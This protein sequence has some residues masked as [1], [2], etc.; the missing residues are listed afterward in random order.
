[1]AVTTAPYSQ[2]RPRITPDGT[3]G[4]IIVWQD[5]RSGA[6]YDVYA[7]RLDGNGVPQWTNDGVAISRA[8]NNPQFLFPQ[9][10][11]DGS[12]GAV[13]VWQD[14][15]N[16]SW[17]MYAQRIDS[18]GIVQWTP[19]GAA[20]ST[21]GAS[22]HYVAC[23]VPDG[24]GG[25]IIAW[26]S[27]SGANGIDVYAQKLNGSG[28]LQWG[29]PGVVLSAAPAD[30][31]YLQMAP[32]GSGGAI[33]VWED[34]RVGS[35]FRDI[36]AQRVDSSGN[37]IWTADGVPV[38]TADYSQYEPQIVNDGMGG[39]IIAW[40][41]YRN[42]NNLNNGIIQGVDIFVQRINASGN[43]VWTENGKAVS[44]ADL[45]QMYPKIV[46]DRSGGA[47]V[48]WEDERSGTSVDIYAQ[49]I[50]TSGHQ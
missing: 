25:A 39:A 41:D 8:A 15:R 26:E 16:G 44:T 6:R 10:I 2:E 33:V 28:A 43:A 12:G 32:A 24:T 47:I 11:P 30:Q 29:A 27:S 13:I 36:Y 35:A 49:G 42:Y 19:N 14:M 38:C 4:A 20:V 50:S 7:Q 18:A 23:P 9:I 5:H 34:E 1:V 3:G 40:Y 31:R 48:V 37:A 17:F 21:T 46:A 22:Y 45:H